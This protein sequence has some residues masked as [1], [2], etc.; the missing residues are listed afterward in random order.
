MGPEKVDVILRWLKPY[1]LNELQIFLGLTGFHCWNVQDH[2]KIIVSL[3]D[4]LKGDGK[5]FCWSEPR[6]QS[7]EKIKVAITLISMM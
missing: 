3:T 1:N 5:F 2:A 7:C 4:L 6:C